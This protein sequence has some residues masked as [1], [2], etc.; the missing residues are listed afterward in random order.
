MPLPSATQPV[1]AELGSVAVP[2]AEQEGAAAVPLALLTQPMSSGVWLT[3]A[4]VLSPTPLR[5]FRADLPSGVVLD[6]WVVR[7]ITACCLS[8]LQV[9]QGG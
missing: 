3:E 6:E 5:D 2:T 7:G 9:R 1:A 8:L 4:A